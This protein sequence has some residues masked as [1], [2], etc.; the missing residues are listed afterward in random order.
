LCEE[1][2]VSSMDY[3]IP[4]KANRVLNVILLGLLLILIR[5]WYLATIQ[6]DEHVERSRKPK[7]RTII[8]RVERATIRDRFNIPLALNKIQYNAAVC[9]A[10]IRQIP[11]FRWEKDAKGKRL[12]IQERVEYITKLSSLLG[13]ELKMDPQKIEDT[14]HGKASLFPHTPFVV[15]EDLTEKEYY[16]LKLLEKDWI[17]ICAEKGSKRYYPKGEMASDVIGFMGA[18]SSKEYYGIASELS[19]LQTYLS[20]REAGNTPMLP[21]GFHNP[22]Q[23][24]ERLKQLQEKAYTINDFIGKTGV[25]STFDPELR[26]YT[27]KKIYE[28]DIKGNIVHELPGSRKSISGQRL[29]LSLSSELQEYA[30]QLLIEHEKLR[31][32]RDSKGDPSLSAPWIKG[33]AIVAMDPKTGEILALASYPRIDLND[34]I[35]SK[36]HH[37]QMKKNSNLAKWLENETYLG[38]IWDGKRLLERDRFDNEAHRFL[39]ES[40]PLTL[41]KYFE[42]TLSPQCAARGAVNKISTVG[43]A[44]FLQQEAENLL[45]ISGQMDMKTLLAALY[46]EAPH[47]PFRTAITEEDKRIVLERLIETSAYTSSSKKALD[48]YLAS[49]APND[50]KLLIIDLCRM[51]VNKDSF[52]PDLGNAIGH[53]SLSQYRQLTQAALLI[54]N[55]LLPHIQEWF[56]QTDFQ[57]WREQNFKEY[58]KGKRKE[59]REK[60]RYARPYTE[61]LDLKERELFK[62]FWESSRWILTQHF[63]WAEQEKTEPDLIPYIKRFAVLRALYPALQH[64]IDLLRESLSP[65]KPN[66]QLSFL[67][68]LRAFQEMNRPLFGRY[69]SVRNSKGVQLEKHLAAAFYPLLGFC[70]GRSQ[71]YRQTTPQ[72]SVFK[73]V[74]AYQ[75]L[76]ERYEALKEK[77]LELSQVN[78]LTLIDDYKWHPKAGSNKQILG[79]TLDGQVITRL[80]KGGILPRGHANIGKIDI[81]GAIEQSSN[82]Y[83]AILAAEHI[84]DPLNLLHATKQFGFGEKSGIELPGEIPG[85][86]PDDLSHNR[87]SLYSFSM[88]QHSLIVTPLQTAVMMS[89]IANKGQILKP[90]IVKIIAGREPLR[91]YRDPFSCATY[92]FQEPLGLIGIDFQLFTS[93]QAET[94]Q[95]QVWYAAPEIKRSLFMPDAIRAPL[96][97]G[98]HRVITGPKGTAKPEIIRS[99]YQNPLWRRDYLDLKNHLMGKTG[100]AEIL[101]KQTL[102][103]ETEPKIHNHIWFC[104]VSLTSPHALDEQELVVVV[105][106]RLSEAGGKE[107]APLA[108]EIVKKWREICTKRSL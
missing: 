38:D 106:L 12:R 75:A 100:T 11:N 2:F 76:L 28:I 64:Q 42:A 9:Y 104:G 24:R 44:L 33:G 71:A 31:E 81:V 89:A 48:H 85:T 53:F 98:M 52:N 95:A 107:A 91:E 94:G 82:I 74:V 27:G 54:Q 45:Q 47:R 29:L 43:D 25:E 70:Y 69:R 78:P 77:N 22:F 21:K 26:G 73:M 66:D 18:I 65:L 59:E 13:K 80:Y 8:E 105:Y 36:I 60:K 5:V 96:V 10:D 103:V 50:D 99:L 16:R 6:H 4:D 79:Y 15:K 90:S 30:E 3:N 19:L 87:T 57:Q 62:T 41:E 58:L 32:V 55:M 88:G 46:S 68:T 23:V 97:E 72:G 39:K 35:P 63:L 61:Y 108:I 40:I 14:I 17:G 86:L 93:M 102:D 51:L 56:H 101:F 34:F 83:F 1:K 67:K 84:Q 37:E 7:R 49:I 92:A 20:E